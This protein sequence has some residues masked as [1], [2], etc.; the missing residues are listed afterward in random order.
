LSFGLGL[1]LLVIAVVGGAVLLHYYNH[2]EAL[3][4]GTL[5]QLQ[6]MSQ[7]GTPLQQACS[8]GSFPLHEQVC[9]WVQKAVRVLPDEQY[10][11]AM[12]DEL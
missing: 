8:T 3:P 7:Q 1:L 5:Q 11:E 6:H 4:Y 10:L 12:H 2:P 9:G